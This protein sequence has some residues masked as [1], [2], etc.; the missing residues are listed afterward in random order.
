M[1]DKIEKVE[2]EYCE[3][4]SPEYI[5]GMWAKAIQQYLSYIHADTGISMEDLLSKVKVK[6][7]SEDTL[8]GIKISV[9]DDDAYEMLI[10]KSWAVDENGIEDEAFDCTFE[11]VMVVTE[12]VKEAKEEL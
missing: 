3:P 6:L 12:L 1:S 5:R 4:G 7:G 11:D 2:D 10:F 8:V 9:T